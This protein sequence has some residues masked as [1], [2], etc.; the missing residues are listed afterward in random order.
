MLEQVRALGQRRRTPEKQHEADRGRRGGGAMIRDREAGGIG[1]RERRQIAY[2]DKVHK[3]RLCAAFDGDLEGRADSVSKLAAA[4]AGER[5]GVILPA[6]GSGRSRAGGGAGLVV[7]ADGAFRSGHQRSGGAAY[8]R[9]NSLV[10]K[11][12]SGYCHN[13]TSQSMKHRFPFR[14]RNFKLSC[15][16]LG[17]STL[18]QTYRSDWIVL[19][20]RGKYQRE[21]FWGK[22]LR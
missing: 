5:S 10:Q 17:G 18:G 11:H 15:L 9:Q 16:E 6:A 4:Q 22:T 19:K 8:R 12:P 20:M 2:R 1:L 13:G 14:E 3:D 21:F 7:A